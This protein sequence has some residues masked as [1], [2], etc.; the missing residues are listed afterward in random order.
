MLAVSGLTLKTPGGLM[1]TVSGWVS[2]NGPTVA[3][4]YVV[5]I[6]PHDGLPALADWLGGRAGQP[7]RYGVAEEALPGDDEEDSD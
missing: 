3:V 5:F 2:R 6:H 7:L 4:N 1:E